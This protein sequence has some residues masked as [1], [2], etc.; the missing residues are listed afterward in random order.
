MIN[1]SFITEVLLMDD[2]KLI[3]QQFIQKNAFNSKKCLFATT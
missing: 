2:K 3:I 1:Q